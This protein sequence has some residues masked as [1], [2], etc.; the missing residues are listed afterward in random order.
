MARSPYS[1]VL[2][3]KSNGK[4]VSAWTVKYQLTHWLDTRTETRKVLEEHYLV[5]RCCANRPDLTAI[6]PWSDI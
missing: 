5:V 3:H 4:I 6:V 1:Y 2:Q